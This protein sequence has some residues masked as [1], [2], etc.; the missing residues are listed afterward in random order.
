[1]RDAERA[2][3]IPCVQREPKYQ[4]EVSLRQ[5][6]LPTGAWNAVTLRQWEKLCEGELLKWSVAVW[7]R[8][9][10]SNCHVH[11]IF[12]LRDGSVWCE[13]WRQCHTSTFP[14]SRSSSQHYCVRQCV[15]G[16]CE[17]M[18]YCCRTEQV[19]Y[20]PRGCHSIAYSP[21]QFRMTCQL[22][23]QPLNPPKWGH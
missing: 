12:S 19:E 4:S 6:K 3:H 18:D 16:S 21:H 22:F 13:L 15:R 17:Y 11:E 1:M 8:W 10:V 2:L 5:A 14:P 20:F 23:S 9:G 7:N